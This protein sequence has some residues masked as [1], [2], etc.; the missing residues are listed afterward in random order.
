MRGA[1]DTQLSRVI[2]C[3]GDRVS[4]L[5]GW[6][7]CLALVCACVCALRRSCLHVRVFVSWLVRVWWDV[8][9]VIVS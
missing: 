5:R 4:V 9:I 1:R 2:V 6:L 3:G 8:M 7:V